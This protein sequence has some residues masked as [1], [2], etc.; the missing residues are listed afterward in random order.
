MATWF[1]APAL[2]RLRD[3][4]N[5]GYPGRDTSA[6][7]SIGDAA[8][9]SR[10][11]DHNPDGTGRVDAI[12]V[13]ENPS[14]GSRSEDVGDGIWSLLIKR[15]PAQLKYAI[16]EGQIVS[17][18][19]RSGYPAYTPR[20]YSGSNPH[21]GHVHVSVLDEHARSSAPWGLHDN[22]TTTAGGS[23]AGKTEERAMD[24]DAVKDFQ[25][26]LNAGGFDA[27][28]I[29]GKW[30]PKTFGAFAAMVKAAGRGAAA[31]KHTHSASAT[32]TIR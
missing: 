13:D 15:R 25:R 2:V 23:A 9:S 18:Y 6:D 22:P 26:A 24:T 27:G 11:S 31:A 10:K 28:E 32:V 20:P 30:G 3:E 1:L 12:D 16:Y 7:G 19:P 8:H 5:A 21:A 29:D 17:S 4:V 14:R